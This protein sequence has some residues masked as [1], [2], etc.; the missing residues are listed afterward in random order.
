MVES[1]SK[2]GCIDGW[3]QPRDQQA[4]LHVDKRQAG[5]YRPLS[6]RRMGFLL[7]GTKLLNQSRFEGIYQ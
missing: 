1:T 6:K 7:L 3:W 2:D 4:Q 5:E